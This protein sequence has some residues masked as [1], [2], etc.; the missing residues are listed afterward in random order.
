MTI[1]LSLVD[2]V[3]VGDE[4]YGEEEWVNDGEFFFGVDESDI[5]RP[6]LVKSIQWDHVT[7]HTLTQH[8][9]LYEPV[10][11][12]IAADVVSFFITFF[13]EHLR[14]SRKQRQLPNHHP[15]KTHRHTHQ[16][17]SNYFFKHCWYFYPYPARG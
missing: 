4:S 16:I 7:Q 12:I 1:A 17:S 14:Q 13:A 9:K 2:G 6:F 11:I 3:D 15:L 10:E 5:S 8:A